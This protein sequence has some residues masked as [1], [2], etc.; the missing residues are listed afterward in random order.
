MKLTFLTA[1][2]EEE[3]N[4]VFKWNFLRMKLYFSDSNNFIL[5]L[6]SMI[7]ISKI[8]FFSSSH[9]IYW[10]YNLYPSSS[11]PLIMLLYSY[12]FTYI[13]TPQFLW[14][15]LFIFI[16]LKKAVRNSKQSLIWYYAC[17]NHLSNLNT[18]IWLP[19]K[20]FNLIISIRTNDSLSNCRS[21]LPT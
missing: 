21:S 4:L 13:I 17:P 18:W 12:V 10:T 1:R 11:I 8:W 2:L 14:F 7:T 3:R 15:I 6:A 9:Y 20:L 5:W 16:S 19:F